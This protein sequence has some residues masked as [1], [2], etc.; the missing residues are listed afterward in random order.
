MQNAPSPPPRQ[1][2][3]PRRICLDS[4]SQN[5]MIET[6]TL[7]KPHMTQEAYDA[8]KGMW[9]WCNKWIC[10]IPSLV[11]LHHGLAWLYSNG[12]NLKPF[13]LHAHT[14]LNQFT[15][16]VVSVNSD[17]ARIIR[18]LLELPHVL[19][20]AIGPYNYNQ[21]SS[22]QL[23]YQLMQQKVIKAVEWE[24]LIY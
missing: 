21:M 10:W 8:T 17:R 1:A 2:R 16:T 20:V 13:N 11:I 4:S 14:W 18:V 15:L 24:T 5:H 6:V 23:T 7:H 22:F 12:R 19:Y 9:S 3:E